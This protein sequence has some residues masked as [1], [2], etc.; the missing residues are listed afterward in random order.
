MPKPI[1]QNDL[2]DSTT[3]KPI[4]YILDALGTWGPRYCAYKNTNGTRGGLRRLT[5]KGFPHPRQVL[6]LD[7]QFPYT[8]WAGQRGSGKS[9]CA[10]WDAIFT[11]Y[12]VPG[13][14]QIIFR[15]T[16]GELERTIIREFL[17]LPEDLRGKF[18]NSA[19]SPH[20]NFA[21]GSVVYFAS[22]NDEAAARKYLSG[23]FLKITFDE[24]CEIPFVWWSF[25]TGSA[26]STI[27]SDAYNNP[28]ISQ[29]KGLSNPGGMGADTL[30]NLFGADCEKNCPRNLDIG[31]DPDDYFFIP[32]YID[33]NP[34]YKADTAAGRAYRKMLAAQ[35]KP[36]REAWLN[37]K[38]TGFEGMYF[39]VFDRDVAMISHN[40]VLKLMEKQYWMPVFLGIDWGQVHHAYICWNTLV[41]FQLQNGERKIIVV[42]FDEMIEKGLSERALAEEIC[43]RMAGDEK[44]KKR[45]NKI[46]LSPETFGDS[47]HSRAQNMGD[48]F[49]IHD[50]PRPVRAKAEKNSRVNGL[51]QMYSLLYERNTLF[52]KPWAT[53][54]DDNLICDWLISDHC[55]EL[56]SAL[57]W[58]V[59]DVDHDGDIRKEGDDPKLDVLDGTRY[60]IYSHYVAEDKPKIEVHRERMELITQGG[61]IIPSKSMALFAEHVRR[62]KEAKAGQNREYDVAKWS[63]R[64]H[65]RMNNQVNTSHVG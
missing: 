21:N 10:V 19:A 1:V 17:K 50:L 36:I 64:R 57:P 20:F 63:R 61:G 62:M 2:I 3:G 9:F 15:K 7:S 14:T 16:M 48:V 47:K 58:A 11:A 40:D 59:T 25:I 35:P 51:R 31:Y 49:T 39:D 4:P 30:R 18:T 38:W 32:S 42:T 41:E 29:V 28:V 52:D 65:P 37:G 33:D 6:Y 44:L 23:E 55:P 60:A 54:A 53:K 56:L 8:L 24:W 22:V 43:A 5:P 34:A 46:Y 45:I 13:S 12:R 26:R 27:T